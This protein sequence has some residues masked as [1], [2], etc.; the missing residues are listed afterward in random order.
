MYQTIYLMPKESKSF[1]HKKF[2]LLSTARQEHKP[3]IAAFALRVEA[4]RPVLYAHARNLCRNHAEAQ[5][6]VQDAIIRGIEAHHKYREGNLSAWL[7]RILRNEFHN[8]YRKK[9]NM[10]IALYC[11]NLPEKHHRQEQNLAEYE[12]IYND[13]TAAIKT[14]EAKDRLLAELRYV[15]RENYAD[16]AYKLNMPLGTVKCRLWKIRKELKKQL[17]EYNN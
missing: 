13:V 1:A 10:Q 12:A 4:C 17:H 15:L 6:L 7:A 16:I 14:L 5:D 3:C 9:K 2:N 11:D 8:Q